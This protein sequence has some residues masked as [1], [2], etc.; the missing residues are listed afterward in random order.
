MI[1]KTAEQLVEIEH[2]IKDLTTAALTGEMSYL[3]AGCEVQK[4]AKERE[5]L[6]ALE[7]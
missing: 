1:T 7:V 6:W 2:K 5:R 3:S 4:L